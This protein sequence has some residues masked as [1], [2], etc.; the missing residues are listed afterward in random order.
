MGMFQGCNKITALDLNNWD[1][2]NVISFGNTYWAYGG[3]FQDCISLE[4]LKIENWN[5]A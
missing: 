5:M 1:T 4:E 3:M 2:S